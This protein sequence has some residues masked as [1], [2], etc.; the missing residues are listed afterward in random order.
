MTPTEFQQWLGAHGHPVVVDGNPGPQTRGATLQ[1][2]SNTC[3][4]AVTDAEIEAIAARLGCTV[5]QIRAVALV[6]SGGAAFD[7]QGRPK[8]LFE[9]HLF[10]RLTNGEWSVSLFSNPKGGGYAEDSWAKLTMAA[11]KNARAAFSAA[12]WGK[13]QVLGMH[14]LA[15]GYPSAIDMAYSTVTGE[16]AHYE[17][18]VRFIEA[19]GL[20]GAMMAL[21]SDAETCRPF[22]KH[23][24]GPNYEANGAYH[25]KLARAMR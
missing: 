22:A 23:Y 19:N 8:I 5:K 11:S 4:A 2:F 3:A 24:N 12:S 14:W 16:A 17:M 7:K 18:L 13:F 15:L 20:K 9:R 21:S 25:E 10:H 1:V 6:E